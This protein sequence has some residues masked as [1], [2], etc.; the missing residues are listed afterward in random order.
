MVFQNYKTPCGDNCRRGL[1][2]FA[3][4]KIPFIPNLLTFSLNHISRLD[5]LRSA[6]R[7]TKLPPPSISPNNHHSFPL[8]PPPQLELLPPR[9]HRDMS[10]R[11][12]PPRL[13]IFR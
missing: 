6:P 3:N 5:T 12:P 8:S 1:P 4:I 11:K 2:I 10:L 13:K 7:N 9:L